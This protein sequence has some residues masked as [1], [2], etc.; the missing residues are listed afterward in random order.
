MS[1]TLEIDSPHTWPSPVRQ[2]L[3]ENRQLFLDFHRRQI[4]LQKLRE[5]DFL[6][7][8]SAKNMFFDTI[9][10]ITILLENILMPYNIAAY[11]C[12]RLARYEIDCI[13]EDGLKALTSD[14]INHRLVTA[15]GKGLLPPDSYK[16]LLSDDVFRKAIQNEFGRRTGSVWFC[17]SKN[18]LKDSGSVYRLFRSWGGEVVYFN[19]E[20][21]ESIGPCLRS[22]GTP[23]IVRC[24]LPISQAQIFFPAYSQSFISRYIS[25]EIKYPHPP[26]ELDMH[27]QRDLTAEEIIEIVEISSPEFKRLTNYNTWPESHEI[28]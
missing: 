6:D 27:M 18:T 13:I 22:I 21:N 23:C 25:D 10:E 28:R 2:I 3:S 4:E 26:Y 9:E 5:E 15:L 12:T 17:S 20:E 11:H 14:F 19:H 8:L 16:Y 24:S 1:L 7:S